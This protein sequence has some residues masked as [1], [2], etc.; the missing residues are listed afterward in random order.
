MKKI[1][2]GIC[3][4]AHIDCE[5]IGN[6]VCIRNVAIGKGFHWERKE[7]QLFAGEVVIIPDGNGLFWA[8]NE[9]DIESY[10]ESV[11]SSEMK[12]TCHPELLK[13]H[14]V[15]SRSWALRAIELRASL[16]ASPGYANAKEIMKWYDGDGH[17]LFD[18]CADDHC[19]RYQGVTRIIS[20]EARA[21]IK[22]TEGEVLMYGEDVCDARFSK[23]CGGAFE[24]FSSCWEPKDFAYLAPGFDRAHNRYDANLR[25]EAEARKWIASSPRCFCNCND[26]KIL[27][28]ILNDYDMTTTPDFFR[29]SERHSGEE[30]SRWV[31][32][33]TGRHLG[34]I[35]D[36]EALERGTSGRI[37]RLKITGKRGS[38]IVGKELEI[39]KVL[40]ATHL[41]SSAFFTERASN[42]D[43]IFHGAGWGHGVGLC[44]IG[45]AVMAE[46]GYNYREILSH[47]YP[48]TD[49]RS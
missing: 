44:Q 30:L 21:A 31:A 35:I 5:K 17:E 4:A 24:V 43:F 33:S 18:V 47:Y 11:I 29:W 36:L 49:I 38:L 32:E 12:A 40:S 9:I 45:A 19:Q 20:P 28:H 10:L 13:A 23:C 39:R 2:V 16:Q 6:H 46:R 1:R 15:I 7:E 34:D 8:V 42:G 14:A 22:A 48:G 26:D 25:D 3:H 37:I 41:K 27:G